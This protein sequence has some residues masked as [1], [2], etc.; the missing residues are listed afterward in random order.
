MGTDEEVR[1]AT[2]E[3]AA[4]LAFRLRTGE[5]EGEWLTSAEW[6]DVLDLLIA[7]AEDLEDLRNQLGVKR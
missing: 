3:S 4:A 7:I 6:A 1:R 2:L 5:R